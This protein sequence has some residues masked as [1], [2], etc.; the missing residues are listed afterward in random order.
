MLPGMGGGRGG[1]N[2]KQL[3]Q[4]MEKLGIDIEEIQDVS[5]VVIKTPDKKYVFDDAEVTIMEAQG[6]RTYQITGTPETV[7]RASGEIE[8]EAEPADE[9][10]TFTDED[11]ELVV[12]EADV[13]EEAAREALEEAGGQPAQAIVALTGD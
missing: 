8:A 9:G 5:E 6:S 7:D 3:Q 11:V 1:M 4:M 10:P 2:P 12:A 13:T